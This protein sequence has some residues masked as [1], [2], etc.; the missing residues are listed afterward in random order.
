MAPSYFLTQSED[1]TISY[2]PIAVAT[3]V[4]NGTI[5]NSLTIAEPQ[6]EDLNPQFAVVNVAQ[7]LNGGSVCSQYNRA[8]VY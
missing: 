2:T 3:Q 1:I 5:T 6:T 8:L 7:P 4:V